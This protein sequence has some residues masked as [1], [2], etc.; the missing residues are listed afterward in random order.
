[1]KIEIPINDYKVPE[2]RENRVKQVIDWY[3]REKPERMFL[4]PEHDGYYDPYTTNPEKDE[5][6][7]GLT[8]EE[9]KEICKIFFKAKYD[10]LQPLK[11]R[12]G[13]PVPVVITK[14]PKDTYNSKFP[15]DKATYT[16][17]I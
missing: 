12:N 9:V 2:I 1:M 10:V 14:Y 17:D 13:T 6:F 8:N 4:C 5:I 3:F 11:W 16:T 7:R 15:S